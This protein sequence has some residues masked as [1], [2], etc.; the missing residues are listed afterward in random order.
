MNNIGIQQLQKIRD[1]IAKNAERGPDGVVVEKWVL[2]TL[3]QLDALLAN[4]VASQALPGN[5]D[6]RQEQEER[7]MTILDRIEELSNLPELSPG[8]AQELG[9]LQQIDNNWYN[10]GMSELD[11]EWEKQERQE[12]RDLARLCDCGAQ[13]RAEHK[14]HSSKCSVYTP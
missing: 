13:D 8:Q 2:G 4:L 14:P 3:Q 5:T 1:F 10:Q 6:D 11:L 12:I 9:E 7:R